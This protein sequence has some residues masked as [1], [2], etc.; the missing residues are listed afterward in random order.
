MLYY[1][2]GFLYYTHAGDTQWDVHTAF[3]F[4]SISITT[5]GYGDFSPTSAQD[6]LFTMVRR[7]C[8]WLC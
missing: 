1:C 8:L 4:T 3:Y 7:L 5:V 2:V 6:K